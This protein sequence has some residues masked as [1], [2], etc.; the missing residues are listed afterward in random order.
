MNKILINDLCKKYPKILKDMWGDPKSTCLSF[1][2]ECGDGW[3]FLLD[4]LMERIQSHIDNHNKYLREGE[5]PITQ[6]VA[7]QIKEKFGNLRFYHSGGDR[8]CDGLITMAET[9][10]QC[11]CEN[12]GLANETVGHTTKNWIQTLCTNCAKEF[13]KEITY[14]KKMIKLW[15]KVIKSRKNPKRSWK[16]IDEPFTPEDFVFP[17][18]IEDKKKII[19]SSLYG[20]MGVDKKKGKK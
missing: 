9:L 2:I 18:S 12:C 11:T 14:D 13:G 3:Y 16:G 10:S 17:R 6:L 4:N 19:L 5:E 20:V 1:G 15:E 7:N 8:F